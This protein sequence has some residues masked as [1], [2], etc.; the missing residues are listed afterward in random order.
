MEYQ[1]KFLKKFRRIPFSIPLFVLL[2]SVYGFVLLYSASG[3]N[4]EP[5]ALKQIV[6]FSIFMPVSIL[7]AM[8]DLRLIYRCSYLFYSFTVILLII[9]EF[10]GKSAMGATRWI[11]L[12]IFTVQPSEL[13]KIALV[14]MLAKYFHEANKYNLAG[15]NI[16]IPLITSVI[17]IA[18]VIKQPDLGTGMITIIVVTIIAIK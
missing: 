11:D 10:T 5:W 2:I 14:L 4:I 16:L 8:L 6:V 18:L 1:E 9:V 3:G 13:V 12:G 17:P 15:Y 7:I